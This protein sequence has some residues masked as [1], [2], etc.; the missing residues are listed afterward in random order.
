MNGLKKNNIIWDLD[1]T[2]YKQSDEMHD[3]FDSAMAKALIED[4]GLDM[5]FET[6]KQKVKESYK[7]YRDGGQLFYK[8][9]NIDEIELYVAYH[10]HISIDAITP[11]EGF[12]ERLKVLS[13]NQYV[14]TYS[15]VKLAEETLKKIGLYEFFKGRIYSIENFNYLKK[16]EAPNVYYF[17]CEKI[18]IDP[19]DCIFVDDSYSN[20]KYPKQIGIT[21]V[22][23][24]SK[25]RPNVQDFID[26]VFRDALDFLDNMNN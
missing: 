20:H 1:N 23:L 16:N 24:S 14:F 13:Q 9:Y 6:A 12:L 25:E 26:Y 21:T 8:E 3:A 2:L 19:K 22:R 5:D 7:K 4:L 15:P 18:G 11:Y 10:N 17:L